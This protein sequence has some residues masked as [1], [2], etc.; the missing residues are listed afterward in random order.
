MISDYFVFKSN[1][2]DKVKN[3]EDLTCWQ[4]SRRLRKNFYTLANDL[5][6]F[7]KYKLSSQIR[8][9]AVSATANIAEGFG[10]FNYQEKIQFLR[11]SRASVFELQDHLY[12]CLDANY[13]SEEKFNELYSDCVDTAKSINGFISFVYDQRNLKKS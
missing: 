12:S 11:I 9:A 10:R 1:M 3:F 2:Y 4:K 8:Q 6:D 5:P 7:E 13:I